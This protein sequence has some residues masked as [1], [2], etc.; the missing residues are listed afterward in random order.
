M[1]APRVY[2]KFSRLNHVPHKVDSSER[3]LLFAGAKLN[4]VELP[5]I[6]DETGVHVA[7]ASVRLLVCPK[8]TLF[9]C[10]FRGNVARAWSVH[11]RF[12]LDDQLCTPKVPVTVQDS[13]TVLKSGV[14]GDV[15]VEE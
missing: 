9:A 14:H 8:T 4:A 3:V 11:E 5:Q 1:H 10:N 7:N 13:G 15:G 12:V 6:R 2:L